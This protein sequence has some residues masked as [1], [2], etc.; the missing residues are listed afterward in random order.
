[1]IHV[2]AGW[3]CIPG[4]DIAA[5]IHGV[6]AATVGDSSAGYASG[7]ACE[8]T[9]RDRCNRGSIEIRVTFWENLC[10]N[11]CLSLDNADLLQLAFREV[12]VIIRTYEQHSTSQAPAQGK[13]RGSDPD[14]G[15]SPHSPG[16][17]QPGQAGRA[18]CVMAGVQAVMRTLHGLFLHQKRPG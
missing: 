4:N 1:M 3:S 5:E 8:G 6:G 9:V 12:P 15:H 17:S 2:R 13:N 10:A 16:G 11:G 18:G 7:I 14:A